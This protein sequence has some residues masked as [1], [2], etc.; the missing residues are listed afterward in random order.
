VNREAIYAALFE[1]VKNLPGLKSVTRQVKLWTEIPPAEQPALVQE[2]IGETPVWQAGGLP[3]KWRLHVDL[4]LYVH[5]RSDPNAVPAVVLNGLVD[6]VAAALAPGA[7]EE[8]QTLNGLV[9]YCRLNGNVD[10]NCGIKGGQA[11]AVIP[12]EIATT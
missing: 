2:Q 12:I 9:E 4:A 3:P 10:F 6:A 11:V 5:N 7:W 1:R 8:E